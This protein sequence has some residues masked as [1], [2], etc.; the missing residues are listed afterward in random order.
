MSTPSIEAEREPDN[1]DTPQEALGHGLPRWAEVGIA[2]TGLAATSPLLIITGVLVRSTGRPVLFRQRRMGKGGRPFTLVKFRTMRPDSRGRPIT[3]DGDDRITPVGRF[4]RK[5]KL[6]E[7]PELWN[8]LRGD[9][10]LVGPRPEVTEYVDLNDGLWQQVLR[11]RPGITDPLALR[12]PNEEQLLQ[13]VNASEEQYLQILQRFK[14]K[15]SLGYQRERTWFSDIRVLVQTVSV[16]V[17]RPTSNQLH[18]D[19]IV[20]M[21]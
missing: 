3:T 9:M 8:V 7:L 2:L 12:L 1:K 18:W 17:T 4:L 13:S 19:D 16:V 11:V 20:R 21:S 5:T 14:L 15:Q 10:S 6:D